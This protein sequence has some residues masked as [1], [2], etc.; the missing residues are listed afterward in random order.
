MMNIIISVLS[1][2]LFLI[3][4]CFVFIGFNKKDYYFCAFI[5]ILEIIYTV[6]VTI[7]LL[8]TN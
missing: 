5:G 7:Y 6:L 2:F 4:F 8:Q 3:G 1:P